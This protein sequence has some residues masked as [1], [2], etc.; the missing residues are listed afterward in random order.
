MQSPLIIF[1]GT[2]DPIHNG[3]IAIANTVYAKFKSLI[4]FMPT[5]R[6]NYKNPPI[7]TDEE[8]L[9][10]LTIALNKNPQYKID[11][12]EINQSYYSSS[13]ETLTKIRNQVGNTTP[14][15]YIIGEDSLVSLDTW[16]S[17]TE[18]FNLT[19]FIVIKRPKYSY[20]M[21][22]PKLKAIFET[23]KTTNFDNL[24]VA[25]GKIYLLDFV[26]SDISSTSIRNWIKNGIDIDDYVPSTVAKYI[27]QH[28]IYKE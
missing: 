16:D 15:Y 7:A 3:H 6:P 9:E 5:A 10:M 2:F 12:L 25:Y 4:T 13:Y 17:W 23:Q 8:R 26:L 18:L 22:S 11:T 1:G 14:I 21:M 19:N 20:D 27:S 28:N 24:D